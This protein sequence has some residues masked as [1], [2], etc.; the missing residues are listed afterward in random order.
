MDS[1]RTDELIIGGF[2]PFLVVRGESRKG[3]R[4][5]NHP[6]DALIITKLNQRKHGSG[7][8]SKAPRAPELLEPPIRLTSRGVDTVGAFL[9]RQPGAEE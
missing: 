3:E 6:A 4:F 7:C 8:S 9:L 2:E 1:L 5:D